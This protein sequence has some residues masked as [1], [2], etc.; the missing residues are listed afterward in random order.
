MLGKLLALPIRLL[1]VPARSLEI[2]LGEDDP[3]DRIISQP[4]ESVAKA[5]EEAADGI[6]GEGEDERL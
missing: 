3:E 6:E 5:V 2:L 4:L 1:N